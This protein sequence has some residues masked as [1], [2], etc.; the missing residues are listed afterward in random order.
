M[1]AATAATTRI[2]GRGMYFLQAF[3][4]IGLDLLATIFFVTL[5]WLSGSIILATALGVAAGIGRYAY[6]KYRKQPIGPLQY[7]SIVLVV[8]SGVTTLITH[9]PLFVQV[10][11]SIISAAVGALMLRTNWMDPY[12]PPIVKGNLE[13]RIILWAS[14]GW[15]ILLILLALGNAGVALLFSFNIWAWYSLVVPMSAQL[16][17]FLVQYGIFRTLIRRSIRARMAAQPAQ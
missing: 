9:D 16:L 7:V 5:Y 12:L 1:F 17:A 11:S 6:M 8:V 13:P 4:P 2:K 3:K 14:H 15:G 10:K